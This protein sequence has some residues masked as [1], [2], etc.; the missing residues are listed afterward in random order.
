MIFPKPRITLWLC[1]VT[2]AFF[3]GGSPSVGA[4]GN[5]AVDGYLSG[6]FWWEADPFIGGVEYPSTVEEGLALMLDE[7]RWVFSGMIYGF[8]FFYNP[9]DPALEVEEVFE[10]EPLL[11]I[12][13]GDPSLKVLNAWPRENRHR[14]DLEYRLSEYQMMLRGVW[15]GNL[16]PS[17]EGEGR[18]TLFE[19]FSGRRAALERGVLQAVRDYFRPRLQNRP[20]AIEGQVALSEVPYLVIREGEYRGRVRIRMDLALLSRA[21]Y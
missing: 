3:S 5:S 15:E 1:L 19:G 6:E 20:A 18:Y 11:S 17:A 10:L 12:P 21:A 2:A 14:A 16:L 4:A 8:R 7:A 9:P 13:W